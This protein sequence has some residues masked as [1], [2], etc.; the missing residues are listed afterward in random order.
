M[1]G[2][3]FEVRV[4]GA[5]DARLVVYVIDSCEYVGSR[6]LTSGTSLLTHKGN[7]RFCAARRHE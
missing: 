3:E 4:E 6:Y 7:C 2:S 1:P 5:P